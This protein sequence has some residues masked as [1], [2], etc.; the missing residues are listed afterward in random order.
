[1]TVRDKKPKAYTFSKNAGP[2]FHLLP[3]DS[4]PMDY[5]CLYFSDELLN[6]V[7]ETNKYER[8]NISELQL[9]P[10]SIW[11]CWSDVSFPGMKAFLGL[12]INM[13]VMPLNDVKA[14]GLVSGYYR[15]HFLVM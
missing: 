12:I 2:Q 5:F 13:G 14:I 10:I 8:Q 1:V 11:S 15:Y 9:S 6:N 7:A 4:E 3:D